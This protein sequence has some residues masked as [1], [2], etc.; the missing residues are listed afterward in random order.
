MKKLALVLFLFALPLGTASAET[1]ESLLLKVNKALEESTV[2]SDK[3]EEAQ[4]LRN[5]AE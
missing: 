2:S 1:C 3:K 4:K 5:E